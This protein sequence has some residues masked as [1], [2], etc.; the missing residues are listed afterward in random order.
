LA[1]YV[2]I[3]WCIRKCPYCDF[4][5]HALSADVREKA[6]VHALLAD[7]EQDLPRIGER[8]VVSIFI[9][10]GTPSLFSAEAIERLLSGVRTRLNLYGDLEVTLEANPGTVEQNKFQEFRE[11]GVNRLSIGVQSFSDEQLQQL[12]RIHSQRE[13]FRAI[14]AAHEAGFGNLNLDLMFGLPGQSL[15][16]ALSD[17]ATAIALEPTHISHYQLTLE[18]GTQFYHHP[19]PD[20]PDEDLLGEMQESCQQ[21]LIA[22]GYSHYE[23]SAYARFGKYCRHNLNY[24][25]FGDYLGIGA[26]A[27][28][29][30]TSHISGTITRFWKLRHPRDYLA[31]AGTSKVLGGEE[32]VAEAQLPF[33]FMLNALRLVEGVPVDLFNER[34]GLPLT[35][36]AAMLDRAR[37]C[38]LLTVTADRL[39]PTDL[40]RRF[41]ND[42]IALFLPDDNP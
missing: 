42:L 19:P 2:H 15:Q 8:S 32:E 4:N 21:R 5:S 7:L 16:Q 20:L 22:K 35:R 25:E 34:T 24:W 3:P 27:H 29:K 37:D 9:G 6:Y 41:L 23:V 39:C 40:G 30:L 26:G 28:S 33:E 36:V 38:D 13:A 18:R 17:I 12:G 31:H 1:L 11:V 14:G 10:G